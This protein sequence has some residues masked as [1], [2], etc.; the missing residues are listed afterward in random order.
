M[1]LVYY[2]IN[3]QLFCKESHN[4]IL[5]AHICLIQSILMCNLLKENAERHACIGIY[6]IA[7]LG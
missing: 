4:V 6:C 1:P 7:N 3:L 2:P 5:R